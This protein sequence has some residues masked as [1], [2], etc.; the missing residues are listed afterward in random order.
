[1]RNPQFYQA[2]AALSSTEAARRVYLLTSVL[3]PGSVLLLRFPPSLSIYL[4]L[5]SLR[6][7]VAPMGTHAE[8]HL[9]IPPKHRIMGF[10]SQK[11][12]LALRLRWLLYKK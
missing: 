12:P 3:S 1:M 9:L 10:S 6:L 8:R 4:P 5:I 11:Q 7:R 2:S